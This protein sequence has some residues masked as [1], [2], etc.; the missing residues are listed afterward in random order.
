M[1]LV[2]YQTDQ[3][4]LA[5]LND[6]EVVESLKFD[7]GMIRT[8]TNNFSKD[9]KLGEGGFGEVYR[10]ITNWHGLLLEYIMYYGD[11]IINLSFW[12]RPQ[13]MLYTLTVMILK[14]FM[15]CPKTVWQFCVHYFCIFL[16]GK[17]ET[18][19]EVAV[20]RLSR[21]SRQGISEF[22]TEVLLVAELQHRN[23]VKL[24]G[25]CL[26]T[27]ETLLVYE[28]L[29]NSSLDRFLTGKMSVLYKNIG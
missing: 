8:A 20:K 2:K 11:S 18:G 16:Q 7:I 29:P 14:F 27:Q 28:Y 26:A 15:V 25:F 17:L 10:V 24:L 23:L 1:V 3:V 4:S 9:R 6:I 12:L 19:E 5:G 13:N 22:K 21:F